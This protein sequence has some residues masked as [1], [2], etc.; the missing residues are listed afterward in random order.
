[1]SAPRRTEFQ[2]AT[3]A[4]FAAIGL[5]S[6]RVAGQTT[7][8]DDFERPDGPVD[9][10][11]VYLGDWQISGGA[12]T[13]T[14][15]GG[16]IDSVWIWAGFPPIV[17]DAADMEIRAKVTFGAA[18]G[19]A[20]GRHGGLMFC[21]PQATFRGSPGMYGYTLDWFDSGA[22]GF[23][24]L[25]WDAAGGGAPTWTSLHTGT[26]EII[27]IPQEW[28]I[29]IE[30][31][32]IRVLGDGTP[33][34]E[35]SDSTYRGGHVGVWS[36][37]NGTTLT[38][39]DVE[40]TYEP[41]E[42]A[43]CFTASKLSG[44]SP[45]VVDFDASCT[46]SLNGVATYAWDFGDG[47]TASGAKVTHTFSF[48]GSY[49][50]GLTV[51]DT[52]DIVKTASVTITVQ[53]STGSFSDDFE[54]ADGPVDGW[55]VHSGSWNIESGKLTTI[56]SGAENWAWAGDPAFS[57]PA[58]FTMTFTLEFRQIPTDG[59]GRHGGVMFC[60]TTPTNRW[61]AAMKG[62]SIDWIDRAGDHGIR[63]IRWDHVG[64]SA[65]TVLDIGAT[66]PLLYPDP[67]VD[68]QIVV[69]GEVIRIFGDGEVILEARDSTYRRG[70]F[71]LWGYGSATNSQS[72][73]LDD[74]EVT[75]PLLSP[76]FSTMPASAVQ[77]GAD[78]ALDASC[79]SATGTP[80]TTYSW[81]FGDGTTGLGVTVS[82]VYST[83]GLKT[84]KLT[85]LTEGGLS[86]TTERVIDAFIPT[87]SFE[88]NFDRPDGAVDGWTVVSGDWKL[89]EGALRIDLP[90]DPGTEAWTF[91][92]DP[93][94]HFEGVMAIE[95]DV[96]FLNEAPADTTLP[97]RHGGIFFFAQ[98]LGPRGA[99]SGYTVDWIDRAADR[100]YHIIA[101][102]NGAARLLGTGGGGDVDPG[103]RWRIEIDGDVIQLYVDDALKVE[104]AETDVDTKY[105]SGLFG[106]WAY[107][108]NVATEF[109]QTI[110]FDN[111][112]IG[113]G[114]PPLKVFHRGDANADGGINITD[115][116]YVLNFLFLG[117]PAPPCREAANPN[118]DNAINI[119]DGIYILNFLF[120][121]G[122]A[123]TAP[124]PTTQPCGPDPGGV[125]GDLGCD[126][127]TKC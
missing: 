74:V 8:N 44:F 35:V 30:G 122:A 10:W 103:T 6:G 80:I 17:A 28:Q 3:L 109:V 65:F 107:P 99:T 105:R 78:M 117:G 16:D 81:D 72:L 118:D 71:G 121:G 46:M 75:S 39:D 88:D 56:T 60:A 15:T 34:I 43:A 26:P 49:M 79:S 59:V 110:E 69:E 57:F 92:G 33:I 38:V 5:A 82:H 127:Y 9:G 54:R 77:V 87:D 58:N 11:S 126:S 67:P 25:R 45:L 100:G 23:R 61:D 51:T 70:I 114:G 53:E 47:E 90:G 83:M 19:D 84:V 97:G 76:C 64:A 68:W 98:A 104:V 96:S 32:I 111:L 123:P 112:V 85:V 1:M 37:F 124:G 24:L 52:E 31:D 101:F 94:L 12:M 73:A 63:L 36:D 113:E 106:L 89:A 13:V 14:A 20:V 95:L 116:I 86:A 93:V 55:T 91:A 125:T 120:L 29:Q 27:D 48:G 115:G 21:A 2:L 7:F 18:P 119:T 40:I 41:L 22:T 66:D 108:G 42:L 62:Y 50:V 4:L 102:D